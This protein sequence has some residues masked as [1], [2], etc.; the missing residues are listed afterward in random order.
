L[1]VE[2]DSLEQS[3]NNLNDG[4]PINNNDNVHNASNVDVGINDHFTPPLDLHVPR[5]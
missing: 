4:N 3:N 5:N 1:V 2:E